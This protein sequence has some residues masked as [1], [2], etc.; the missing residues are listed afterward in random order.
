MRGRA[1]SFSTNAT[2]GNVSPL[3][4][5]ALDPDFLSAGTIGRVLPFRNDSFETEAAGVI[6][7][8]LPLL[9]FEEIHVAQ[10]RRRTGEQSLQRSLALDQ[11]RGSPIK[12]GRGEADRKPDR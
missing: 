2:I 1:P 3:G 11:R 8:C 10:V 12:I 9:L 6:E 4:A 7:N 5:L